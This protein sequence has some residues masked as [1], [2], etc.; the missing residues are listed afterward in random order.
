[1]SFDRFILKPN[2]AALIVIDIQEKLLAAMK[3]D[4]AVSVVR[5]A[6]ILIETAKVF[7]IPVIV[8]EQY[9]KGLGPT[10]SP[11][12]EKLTD[13]ILEKLH[14]DCTKDDVLG[15]TI[16]ATGKKTFVLAGIETHVCV[17]QTAL[18]LLGKG[19][20]VVVASD[21]VASRRKHDW[22]QSLG[23]L[24]RAG[25]AVYPTETISFIVME[26]AGTEEFK[27]LA[28]LFK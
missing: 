22:K 1:M 27:K 24:A 17:F 6:G 7:G 8:S 21:A 13:E 16:A 2:D 10:I 28:P 20:A 18:S 9:R 26:K 3:E 19:Y 23:A 25:A 12:R 4:I 5:N 15:K 14:F 11:L